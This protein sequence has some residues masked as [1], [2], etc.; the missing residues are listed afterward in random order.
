[1]MAAYSSDV[2]EL[3]GTG[4]HAGVSSAVAAV[5]DLYGPADAATPGLRDTSTAVNFMKK[6]YEED[7]H[8]FDMASPIYHLDASDPPTLLIHGAIDLICP[9]TQSDILAEKMQ[10]LGLPYWYARIDGW[11]HTLDIVPRMNDY[12]QVL[13]DAFLEEYLAPKPEPAAAR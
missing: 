1:M 2:P 12:C 5:V 8:L 10:A 4:G 7:P 6:R 11:P 9:V 3:E 13:L